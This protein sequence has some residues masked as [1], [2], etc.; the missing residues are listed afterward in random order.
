MK[1]LFI[2]LL[3]VLLAG[4]TTQNN[5]YANSQSVELYN[6]PISNFTSEQISFLG[7]NCEGDSAQIAECILNWQ[8]NNFLYANQD[9]Q[10]QDISDVIRWNYM[11]PGIYPTRELIVERRINDKIYGVCFDYAITYCSIA[12]YYNLTCRVANSITK[13]SDNDESITITTGMSVEE[14]LR[15]KEKLKLNNLDYSYSLMNNVAMETPEHYW[16]EVL[17]DNNWIVMDA[18]GIEGNTELRYKSVNDWEVT[19]FQSRVDNFYQIMN[20]NNEI[21][22]VSNID[23]YIV[24]SELGSIGIAPYYD[25]C[26]Q[27]CEFFQGTIN[28][29]ENVCEDDFEYYSCYESCSEN[30]YY[31]VCDFICSNDLDYNSCYESCSGTELDSYCDLNC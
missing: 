13:P 5:N 15:L 6:S 12:N 25:N 1:K 30:D 21:E 3:F 2:L 20:L 11:I 14:Y 9:L 10:L 31:I 23:D 7:I 29:C 24:E 27:V 16:A 17:I 28:N 26:E 8:K 4:C 18:S 19:N 22:K